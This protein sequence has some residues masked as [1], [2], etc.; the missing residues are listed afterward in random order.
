MFSF[1][2]YDIVK[3]ERIGLLEKKLKREKKNNE[4]DSQSKV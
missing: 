1:S 4:Q 3:G 2:M